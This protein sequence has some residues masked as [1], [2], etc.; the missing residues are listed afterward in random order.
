[1]NIC[2]VKEERREGR[3]KER[4]RKGNKN[5]LCLLYGEGEFTLTC[6]IYNS[7]KLL[8][9]SFRDGSSYI[10][11]LHSFFTFFP[12]LLYF[13]QDLFASVDV[14]GSFPFFFSF[15][16]LFFSLNFFQC[17][18]SNTELYA[19]Q[20]STLP[21][22]IPSPIKRKSYGIGRQCFIN[23]SMFLHGQNFLNKEHWHLN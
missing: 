4:K 18:G 2:F 5:Y 16:F 19:C 22:C 8:N 21:K 6:V 17:W 7:I 1:M 15:L 13:T 11:Y 14:L 12:S 10:K 9:Q 20:V 3:K 23:S